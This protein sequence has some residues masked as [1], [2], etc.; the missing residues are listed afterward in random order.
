MPLNPKLHVKVKTLLSLDLHV[1][2]PIFNN[3][4][5]L[6]FDDG[7]LYFPLSV[8]GEAYD[9]KFT[10]HYGQDKCQIMSYHHHSR[11][12]EWI[13]K[14]VMCQCNFPPYEK[15]MTHKR[16]MSIKFLKHLEHKRVKTSTPSRHMAGLPTI[17]HLMWRTLL[18]R[19]SVTPLPYSL[20]ADNPKLIM[21]MSLKPWG[22]HMK[23]PA[24]I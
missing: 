14:Y 6:G 19:M 9:L 13:R 2:P 12:V 5:L 4:P 7:K 18:V 3:H 15:M 21:L 17:H 22:R 20:R 24:T 23:F 10:K 11:V 16:V 8:F 1:A